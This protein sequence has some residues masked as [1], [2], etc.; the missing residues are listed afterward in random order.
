M[1]T[2]NLSIRLENQ[3][4]KKLKFFTGDQDP[5]V[6]ILQVIFTTHDTANKYLDKLLRQHT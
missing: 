2:V 1:A 4:S 5:V 6:V 3:F